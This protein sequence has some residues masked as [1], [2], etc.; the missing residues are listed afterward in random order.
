MLALLLI[1][2]T[3]LVGTLTLQPPAKSFR[4]AADL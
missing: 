4:N 3:V 1:C 2:M